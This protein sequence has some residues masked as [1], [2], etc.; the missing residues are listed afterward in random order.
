MLISKLT[1]KNNFSL[2][3]RNALELGENQWSIYRS[4][5][6][7]NLKMQYSRENYVFVSFEKENGTFIHA[8]I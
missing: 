3:K 8:T 1:F 6:S 2:Y 5:S 7:R 4:H